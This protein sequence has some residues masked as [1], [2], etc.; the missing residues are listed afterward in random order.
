MKKEKEFEKFMK[1]KQK[2]LI[3]ENIDYEFIKTDKIIIWTRL[4]IYEVLENKRWNNKMYNL[5]HIKKTK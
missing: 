2:K 4:Y 3:K 5:R 1:E